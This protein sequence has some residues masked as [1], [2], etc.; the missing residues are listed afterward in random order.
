MHSEI[1]S[2]EIARFMCRDKFFV[3]REF[4]DDN[5]TT[6][7]EVW[8]SNVAMLEE[9]EDTW[10]TMLTLDMEDYDFERSTD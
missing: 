9:V 2:G 5:P 10:T 7:V 6:T 4:E 1:Q 8:C 3:V